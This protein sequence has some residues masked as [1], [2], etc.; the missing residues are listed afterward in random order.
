MFDKFSSLRSVSDLLKF[1]CD[2][3]GDTDDQG[4]ELV[5]MNFPL[6]IYSYDSARN[7][8]K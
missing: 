2:F 8:W 7:T 4:D 5:D 3:E 1:R 6:Y